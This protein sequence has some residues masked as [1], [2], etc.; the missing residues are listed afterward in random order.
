MTG[1]GGRRLNRS[2]WACQ[3]AVRV[4]CRAWSIVLSVP[5]WTDA[6]GSAAGAASPTVV[7]PAAGACGLLAV[8][9][10]VRVARAPRSERAVGELRQ[11]AGP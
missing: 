6:G 2:G 1:G 4:F 9:F 8:G 11:T 7:I 3:A 5:K 10:Y